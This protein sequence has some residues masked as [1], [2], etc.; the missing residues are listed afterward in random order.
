MA[1]ALESPRDTPRDGLVTFLQQR[2][3]EGFREF[4]DAMSQ[5]SFFES[6]VDGAYGGRFVNR[7]EL[8]E[9]FRSEMFKSP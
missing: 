7:R 6:A 3:K 4:L 9:Q 8:E 2:G 5:G 1:G